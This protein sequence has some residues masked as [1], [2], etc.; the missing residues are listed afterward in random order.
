MLKPEEPEAHHAL[1]ASPPAASKPEGEGWWPLPRRYLIHLL[2]MLGFWN[3]YAMRVNLSEAAEPMSHLYGW[4]EH[5][6]GI[7]LSSFFVGYVPGQIP[8]GIL[9]K[10]YGGKQILGLGI[11][12]TSVLTLVLPLCAPSLS[13][14]YIVRA[15]MGFGESV[16]FPAANVLY[17]RWAPA[18][19]RAALLAFA[20]A[21]SYLGTACAF[22]VAGGL[23]GMHSDAN[24]TY[25][26]TPTAQSTG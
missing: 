3:V 13:A 9:A 4:S 25:I 2:I 1:L 6:K 5:T 15:L 16:T 21:G 26:D 14:L 19:E 12:L 20:N 22:P 24:Q 10:R 17:T 23:I 18:P 11:L 8:G 7:V